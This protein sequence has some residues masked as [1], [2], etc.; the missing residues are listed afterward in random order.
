MDAS[1]RDLTDAEWTRALVRRVHA[2]ELEAAGDARAAALKVADR[3]LDR[4]ARL[5]PDA[6][7]GG[8]AL[9]D[10]SR[11]TGVSRPTLY[12]LRAR[13]SESERDLRLAL[14]QTLATSGALSE[15]DLNRRL[16]GPRDGLSE[17][18]DSLRK[19]DFLEVDVE[20]DEDGRPFPIYFLTHHGMDLL[21]HWSFEEEG[22]EP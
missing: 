2:R 8:L 16:G 11:L 21:G 3:Q 22:D 19:Q 13:Y 17:L 5:L 7:Q 18:L 14:V 10:V 9:T 20:E 15:T 4:I 6:L 1:R 12:E